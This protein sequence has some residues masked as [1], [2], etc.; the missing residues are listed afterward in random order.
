MKYTRFAAMVP[1]DKCGVTEWQYCVRPGGE[2]YPYHIH[3]VRWT[4][5]KHYIAKMDAEVVELLATE[6]PAGSVV[7]L[8]GNAGTAWQRLAKGG[9]WHSATSAAVHPHGVN[10]IYLNQQGRKPIVIHVPSQVGTPGT[11]Q[12]GVGG[13]RA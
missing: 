6:P 10:W 13:G 1:C 4:V 11:V 8:H 2:E 9:M 3:D 12:S 5:Q 7:L